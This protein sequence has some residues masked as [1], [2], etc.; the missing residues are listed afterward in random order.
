MH[1]SDFQTFDES[2]DSLGKQ[3][4]ESMEVCSMSAWGELDFDEVP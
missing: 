4:V 2:S 3:W 1:F